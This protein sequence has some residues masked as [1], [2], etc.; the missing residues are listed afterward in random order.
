MN[1]AKLKEAIKGL[2]DSRRL[3]GAS[4]YL[5]ISQVALYVSVLLVDVIYTRT[6]SKSDFGTWK[7]VMLAIQFLIPFI[8]LGL[9]EGFR[10]YSA[11]EKEKWQTH[12]INVI[13]LMVMLALGVLAAVSLGGGKIIA[14]L[15]K[16]EL[17]LKIQYLYPAFFIL[18]TAG[19]LLRYQFINARTTNKF[20]VCQVSFAVIFLLLLCGMLLVDTTT[21]FVL[22]LSILIMAAFAIKVF[23]LLLFSKINIKTLFAENPIKRELWIKYISYGF[24]LY[25]ATFIGRITLNIDKMI[26]SFFGG[27]VAYSVYAIGAIE[28]PFI[29]LI[30]QVVCQALYPRLVQMAADNRDDEMR[31][32][33]IQ[34]TVKISYFTYPLII[35]LMFTAPFIIELLF[36]SSYIEATVIFKAYLLILLWRNNSYGSLLMAKGKTKWITIYSFAAMLLNF[37]L[38][39]VGYKI[40]GAVGVV[41]GTFISVSAVAVMQMMHEHIFGRYLKEFLFRP[42]TLICIVLIVLGFMIG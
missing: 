20:M 35:V 10:Y 7:Q 9:P 3:R 33:W 14:V 12:F 16:N 41:Y 29:T 40:F 11:R 21:A 39:V 25:L 5:L 42:F 17:F 30:S 13:V 4:F 2:L 6:L 28:M 26:V 24:P 32:L 38:S 27:P 8:A 23:M 18:I 1:I 31:D 37:G 22:K 36:S 15:M 34:G 19:T